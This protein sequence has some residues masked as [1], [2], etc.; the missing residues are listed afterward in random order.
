MKDYD[1]KR[2]PFWDE[3]VDLIKDNAPK[4][5]HIGRVGWDITVTEDGKPVVIEYNIGYPGSYLSQIAGGP[6]FGEHTDMALSFLKEEKNQKKYI[7]HW[8]QA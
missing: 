5:K 1:N 8:L 6:L 4:L 3:I 7:P 2:I